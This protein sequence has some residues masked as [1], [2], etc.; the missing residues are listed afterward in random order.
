MAWLTIK[1]AATLEASESKMQD[2][3]LNYA[4]YPNPDQTQA[5]KQKVRREL[6]AMEGS[7]IWLRE[8]WLHD[9]THPLQ[10]CINK[11]TSFLLF[12]LTLLFAAASPTL[13]YHF[14]PKFYVNFRQS[15]VFL[16]CNIHHTS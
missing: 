1:G 2:P 9:V 16:N 14:E 7:N 11:I 8:K 4:I 3:L 10:K 5:K 6:K 15:E 12:I 13:Y